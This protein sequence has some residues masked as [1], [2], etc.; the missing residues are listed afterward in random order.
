M[1]ELFFKELIFDNLIKASLQRLFL[2][3]PLLG[4]GPFGIIITYFANKYGEIF[5]EEMKTIIVIKKIIITNS[6]FESAY[7]KAT[8]KLKVYSQNYGVDS[9]EY[10]RVKDEAKKSL[11]DL[12]Q[13]IITT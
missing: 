8:L 11:A 3:I 5:F 6:A 7:H 12:V 13:F 9:V 2:K 4:W 10:Q 1:L